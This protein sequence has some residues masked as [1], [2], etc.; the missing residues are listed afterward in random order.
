MTWDWLDKRPIIV[1]IAGPNG[2]GKT[3]FYH[4]HIAPSGLRFVNAD[5]L[6]KQFEIDAY[7]AASVADSLR[8]ELV[9]Q[10]ESFAFETVFSDPVRDK[11]R[12]LKEA[13][14]E[15]YTVVLCFIGLADAR[16]SDERVAMRVA[17]GGHDV[18]QQK[19]V[20]R[21]PRTLANLEKAIVELPRV[22][23]YDNSDLAT[24]YQQVAIFQ[25]GRTI[26]IIDNP[27]SWL[28]Q[29]MP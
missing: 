14:M 25:S 29:S 7:A 13:A 1:A 5:Y 24:P 19:L 4:A 11:V 9:K 10:R 22:I 26:E 27:P 15:G 16:L 8:R 2:A 12:F 20:A 17:Q 6:G 21:F 23:V 3:T 28:R 18:P